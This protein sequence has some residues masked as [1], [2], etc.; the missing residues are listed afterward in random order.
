MALW[1]IASAASHSCWPNPINQTHE[2]P[3]LHP[4]NARVPY[5]GIHRNQPPSPYQSMNTPDTS[6][7]AFPGN[8]GCLPGG[9]TAYLGMTL[10]DWFAGQALQGSLC[11]ASATSAGVAMA[12]AERIAQG[13]SAA[14]FVTTAAKAAYVYADAMLL[15]RK[16]KA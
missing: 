16:G 15:A 8:D 11:N 5:R 9:G 7:P 3:L 14:T 12:V 6:E 10:R 4:S 13:K 2:H 1:Y